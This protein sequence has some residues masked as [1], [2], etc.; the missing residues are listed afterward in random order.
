MSILEILKGVIHN[1]KFLDMYGFPIELYLKESRNFKSNSG[2]LITIIV[3]LLAI[4][5]FFSQ[6]DSWLNAEKCTP[7]YSMENHSVRNIL[8]QNLTIQYTLQNENYNIYFSVNAILSEKTLG[9]KDLSKYLIIEYKYSKT[10]NDVDFVPLEYES[11][12]SRTQNEFLGLNYDKEKV[13]VNKTNDFQMCIKYPF[14]LGLQAQ[15]ANQMVWLPI[16]SFE[17]KECVNTTENNFFCASEKEIQDMI[18]YVTV[19]ASIPKTIYD[20]KNKTEPIKKMFQY[21][22]FYLDWNM[23]LRLVSEINPSYLY[24]DFGIISEDYYF[25]NVDFNAEKPVL[26]VR[27]K[28]QENKLLFQYQIRLSFQVDKYFLRNQK[29]GDILGSFG[30]I[31]NIILSFGGVIAFFINQHLL[32]NTLI[33]SA[34]NFVRN[35]TIMSHSSKKSGPAKYIEEKFIYPLHRYLREMFKVG[36]KSDDY[37]LFTRSKKYLNEYVDLKKI[38]RRL[39]DVDKLKS[40]LFND[41]E[42]FFFDLIPKPEII[43]EKIRCSFFSI[44]NIMKKKQN[45]L[46]EDDLKTFFKNLNPKENSIEGRILSFL[47]EKTKQKLNIQTRFKTR[48]K[49]MKAKALVFKF[50]K[51]KREKEK[52]YTFDIKQENQIKDKE[53]YNLNTNGENINDASSFQKQS[54]RSSL[55][56]RKISNDKTDICSNKNNKPILNEDSLSKFNKEESIDSENENSNMKLML[57]I[58][59]INNCLNFK[60]DFQDEEGG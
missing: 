3:I 41:S 50:L 4:L 24:K 11:C 16:L 42:R 6:I 10:G 45:L 58:E 57:E 53:K 33:N 22:I 43:D 39:Q 40:V 9:Y 44:I 21:Q 23:K 2:A 17:I 56:N 7:I 5:S 60:F 34:F 20:F 32:L 31:L 49:W 27:T 46:A 51:E 48:G 38:I 55:I 26:N 1:F 18:Q 14:S 47:D 52:L 25:Q 30:G 35:P 54:E 28:N 15:P 59:K 8:D 13:P 12:N 19:Q 37:I 36:K 29:L